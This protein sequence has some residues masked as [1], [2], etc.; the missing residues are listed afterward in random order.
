VQGR[1]RQQYVQIPL[2][3][4]DMLP[5]M[6]TWHASHLRL[7]YRVPS[8]LQHARVISH[9]QRQAGLPVNSDI[10]LMEL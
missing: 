8:K 2:L 5:I 9:K 3:G 4:S 7:R 6:M 10:L 1:E